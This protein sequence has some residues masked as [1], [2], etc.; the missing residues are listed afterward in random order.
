MDR[1][2]PPIRA[3]SKEP[4]QKAE[5]AKEDQTAK[6][7]CPQCQVAGQVSTKRIKAKVGVS[8]GKATGAVLTGGVSV[9]ATGLSRKKEVS[10]A[11]LASDGNLRLRKERTWD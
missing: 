5:P 6:I 1:L 11:T 9:L 8:G 7:V 4:R 3:R 10:R 2:N